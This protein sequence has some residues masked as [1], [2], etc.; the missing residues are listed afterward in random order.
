MYL[1][2]RRY[3]TSIID[4]IYLIKYVARNGFD[5][6]NFTRMNY[7]LGIIR[8]TSTGEDASSPHCSWKLTCQYNGASKGKCANALCK[9]KG[10]PGGSF[11][12]SSN[13]FCDVSFT[14]D[15]VFVYMVDAN[16][17]E[18][19]RYPSEARITADCV[20]LAG[21]IAFLVS[22]IFMCTHFTL[23]LYMYIYML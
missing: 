4:F 6:L 8:V 23:L 11:V 12:D 7:F 13:N 9:A 2:E 10:Y 17:I 18:Q 3:D 16:R 20:L 5:D 15:T 14:S 22:V 19:V 21:L 1:E